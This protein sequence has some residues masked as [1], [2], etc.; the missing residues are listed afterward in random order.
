MQG[1]DAPPVPWKESAEAPALSVAARALLRLAGEGASVALAVWALRVGDR[2]VDFAGSNSG[3]ATD[4]TYAFVDMV[5]GAVAA[6][7]LGTAVLA[8]KRTNAI[9]FVRRLSLRLSPLLAAWILPLL[10]RWRLWQ[11]R[12]L[13]FLAL[14]SLAALVVQRSV[15]AMLRTPPA[16]REA[17]AARARPARP[18]G[19][20]R[21]ALPF[22][23]VLVAA[24]GY[25][26]YFSYYTL[27]NHFRIGTAALDLGLE[28]N[29]VW[30]AVHWGP[31]FKS[32]PLGGP[33][34]SHGGYHQTY[35]AYVLGI[36][37]RLWPDPRTLLVI[38][39]TF[40]GAAAIPL[41]FL[42]RRRLSAPES[43]IV[44]V[45]YLL[46]APLHG[47]NLYD[48]HYLLLAPLF[49]W[50]VLNL[51]EVRRYGWAALAIAF[52]L[53]IREDVAALLAFVGAY[54]VLS[55]IRPKAG[56]VVA[57]VGG[58]YFVALKMFVMPRFLGGSEAFI[59]MFREL[60]PEG[61]RG[62][63]GVLKTAIGNP[64][65]TLGKLLE[66]DKL[67]YVLQILV[68]FAFL[69]FRRAIGLIC[70][71]P[72]FLFT[73][74]STKYMP[75]IQPTFQ[76][77][78]YWTVFLFIGS[79]ANLGWMRESE[80]SHPA[81]A[82]EWRASRHAWIAAMVCTMLATSYQFGA[83]LQ[84][85]TARGGFGP[86]RFDLTP[87]DVAHHQHVYKLI[88]EVP[89]DAKIV[90]SE[91]IVPHVSQRKNSYTL[92]TGLHDA[93]WLLVWM[94]PRGDERILV[95]QALRA[96]TYGVFDESGEFM[97]AKRGYSTAKNAH[98]MAHYGL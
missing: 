26:A 85:H 68:P 62:Y 47:A 45:L 59:E 63:G 1:I 65:Y 37:Y 2:I 7:L 19:R 3:R 67:L 97:L 42:A 56:I 15:R 75:L 8:F 46:Y 70:I 36:P 44:A 96:G 9:E 48:F 29:L 30:N 53:S 76:Y 40:A 61:D 55:G 90:S 6:V 94:P 50:T 93:E 25:A 43:G 16:F 91:T 64:G 54:L 69:P 17:A 24:A 95:V 71:A 11:G 20:L 52:T 14:V 72:G 35:F 23:G 78:T 32:S 83:I 21:N 39:A 82:V 18:P 57:L 13:T 74:L 41:Y 79:V 38:Q 77:T 34:V 66:R 5:S 81:E 12:E 73:L 60:L 80:L 31:L 92:R 86:F 49:L 28:D 27:R 98:V 89:P 84:Q 58:A 4:R 33:N 10:F 22:V 51:V 88:A 87:A